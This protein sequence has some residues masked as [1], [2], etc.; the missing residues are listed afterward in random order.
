[1]IQN[2]VCCNCEWH[3]NQYQYWDNSADDKLMIFFLSFTRKQG[4]TF[5]ANCLHSENGEKYFYMSSAKNLTQHV[6]LV[7]RSHG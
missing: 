4:L 5:Q 2:V 7:Y 6:D 1:M 3:I